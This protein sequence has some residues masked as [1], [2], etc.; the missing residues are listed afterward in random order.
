MWRAGVCA[1][2]L[3]S[4]AQ[5]AKAAD[6]RGADP[7]QAPPGNATIQSAPHYA[8][9]LPDTFNLPSGGGAA[10]SLGAPAPIPRAEPVPM[11]PAQPVPS[12]KPAK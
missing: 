5:P 7:W 8:P 4:L 11:A 6:V 1:A 9:A 12:D 10:P 2:A 3:M